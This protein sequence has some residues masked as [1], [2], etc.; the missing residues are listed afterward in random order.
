MHVS[1]ST[2]T[3]SESQSSIHSMVR[4]FV[5]E[6]VRLPHE[7]VVVGSL[8]LLAQGRNGELVFA[9]GNLLAL[10]ARVQLRG[11]VARRLC[12]RM[13]PPRHVRRSAGRVGRSGFQVAYRTRAAP[14]AADAARHRMCPRRRLPLQGSRTNP[15]ACHGRS[16]PLAAAP[17]YWAAPDRIYAV[18]QRTIGLLAAPGWSHA[19][20]RRMNQGQRGRVRR[21]RWTRSR[22]ANRR[23]QPQPPAGE[24]P[25]LVPKASAPTSKP[26]W[27]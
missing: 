14:P 19:V 24:S 22:G 11:F 2:Q 9:L 10:L 20:L 3:R 16:S 1:S 23:G 26:R 15:V 13:E 4:K 5:R 12:L 6:K 27:C 7:P 18:H 8:A 17:G 25:A 21:G